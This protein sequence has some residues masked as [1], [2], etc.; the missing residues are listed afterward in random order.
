MTGDCHV[1]FCE[2]LRGETPLC[3]LGAQK[4]G[5]YEVPSTCLAAGRQ[6][7]RPVRFL[8]VSSSLREKSAA[9]DGETFFFL[10]TQRRKGVCL[11]I[12]RPSRKVVLIFVTPLLCAQKEERRIVRS[13]K[14]NVPKRVYEEESTKY[15]VQCTK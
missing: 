10:F 9:A 8:C 3:L 15:Q 13:T 14:Y 11:P 7:Q 12:G 6:E 2:R 1:R 5:L 4:E